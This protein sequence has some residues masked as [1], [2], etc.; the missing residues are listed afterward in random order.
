MRVYCE[1][2]FT[3]PLPSN[4]HAYDIITVVPST[5]GSNF[6]EKFMRFGLSHYYSVHNIVQLHPRRP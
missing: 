4:V 1:N 3:D 5:A 6:T 2:M